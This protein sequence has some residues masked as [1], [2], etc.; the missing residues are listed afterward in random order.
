MFRPC[1]PILTIASIM[2]LFFL[3]CSSDNGIDTSKVIARINNFEL[4]QDEFQK[5]LVTEME[6]SNAYKTTP[7]GKQ[8]FLQSIIEKELFI[9]EARKLG[10]DKKKE[11]I[12]AIERHWE[13]TLIKHLMERKNREILQVASVSENEIKKKY[14]QLQSA[15]SEIPPFDQ[16]EKEIARDL[17]EIKKTDGL[18]AWIRSLSDKAKIKIDSGF[19]NE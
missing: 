5:K 2:T 6:Y 7:E 4:T 15:N 8:A 18:N 9:Q 1:I 17:I 16:V 3:G 19:I 11:F 12:S 13:S 10:L 14:Q